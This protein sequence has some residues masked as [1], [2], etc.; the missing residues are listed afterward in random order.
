MSVVSW[1]E[2]YPK[3][4]NEHLCIRI[5]FL[6]EM[7][8][9]KIDPCDNASNSFVISSGNTAMDAEIIFE[10]SLKAG[11]HEKKF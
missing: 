9:Y 1:V 8:L 7:V 5:I 3:F 6:A 4:E 10:K 2:I 11:L